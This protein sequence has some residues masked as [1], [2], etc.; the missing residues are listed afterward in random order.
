MVDE[1]IKEEIRKDGPITF[2]RFM[3]ICLYHPEHG[4][5]SK[6]PSIG[7]EGDFFTSSSVGGIFGRTLA[8]ALKEML[9]VVGGSV[10]VEMGA[11]TGD[12]AKDVLKEFLDNGWPVRYLIVERSHNLK[13]LQE[14]KLEG[15][16][17]GWVSRVCELEPVCGVFFSNELV[18]AFPVHLVEKRDGKLWEVYVDVD[19]D[20]NFVEVLGEPST[21]RIGF[22]FELQRVELPDGFRTEVNVDIFSWIEDV[23]KALE[24]GF[25]VTIDYG[26]NSYDFYRPSRNRGTLMCYYRHTASEDPFVRPG[27]QDITSHVNFSVVARYGE[28]LGF[29]VVGFTNQVNFLIDA[30]ILDLVRDQREL[31]QVKTLVMPG[32]GMGERFKVLIQG[33]GVSKNVNLRCLRNAPKRRSFVL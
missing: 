27:E 14:R 12:L 31:L 6:G 8:H 33:K 10:L 28:R 20:G 15:L 13:K 5:Y 4:Y 17:V 32:A 3:E 29:D 23:A 25:L 26:Y 11:G 21:E 18:D 30:G 22:F 24:R 19:E 1:V 2:K 16:P 9:D 7:K